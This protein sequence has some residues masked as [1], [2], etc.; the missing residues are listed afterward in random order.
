MGAG[1]AVRGR[2][3][4]RIPAEAAHV[5]RVV[6]VAWS[7]GGEHLAAAGECGTVFV[8]PT[9][10]GGSGAVRPRPLRVLGGHIGSVFAMAWSAD[11]FL[12]TAGADRAVRLWHPETDACLGTFVHPDLVTALSFHPT[13]DNLLLTGACDGVAR[14]WRPAANVIV[15]QSAQGAAV[16]AAAF[17]PDGDALLV[18]RY[19][20]SLTEHDLRT[21]AFLGADDV[22]D[23][24]DEPT[25][26]EESRVRF[27]GAARRRTRGGAKLCAIGQGAGEVVAVTADGRAHVW[28]GS[29]EP[30]VLR[31]KGGHG[32]RGGGGVQQSMTSD[33]RFLVGDAGGGDLAVLDFAVCR[34]ASGGLRGLVRGPSLPLEVVNV[35]TSAEVL[36]AEFAGA[37]AADYMVGQNCAKGAAVY[38]VGGSDGTICIISNAANRT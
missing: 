17:S 4:Q 34:A 35:M 20:G 18:G 31:L 24:P 11:G 28:D 37:R 6:S 19:D 16:S 29:P 5:A 27:A 12:A 14:L 23:S 21:T 15:A 32:W 9:V 7:Q 13:D 8:F 10:A 33:A 30:T 38:A 36:C 1:G 26:L 22:N 3:V 2:V 25:L